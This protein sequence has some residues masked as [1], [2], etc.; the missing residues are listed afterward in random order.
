MASK[1][2]EI[3]TKSNRGGP[4]PG[5]GRPGWNTPDRR[6]EVRRVLRGAEHLGLARCNRG[7]WWRITRAGQQALNAGSIPA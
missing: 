3:Q 6:D 7:G 5:A 1:S 4:R 2:N